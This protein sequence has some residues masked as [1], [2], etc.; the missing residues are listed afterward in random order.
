MQKDV[1]MA[2][3]GK[4]LDAVLERFQ[5]SEC[6]L[7]SV[8]ASGRLAGIVNLD[9]ILELLQFQEILEGRTA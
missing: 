4:P 9:N 1:H 7:V 8:P 5:T 3:I 6:R 2:D